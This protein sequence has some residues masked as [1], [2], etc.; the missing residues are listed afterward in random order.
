MELENIETR[1]PSDHVELDAL[2]NEAETCGE[3]PK[4]VVFVHDPKKCPD[5]GL[6]NVAR[7]VKNN[8][9][10]QAIELR[11]PLTTEMEAVLTWR[12]PSLSDACSMI[13][14]IHHQTYYEVENNAPLDL[15]RYY[16]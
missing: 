2:L 14:Y 7:K 5:D 6:E 10:I 12:M 8:P 15:V 11:R 16:Y 4:F 1:S 13:I 9:N 3:G